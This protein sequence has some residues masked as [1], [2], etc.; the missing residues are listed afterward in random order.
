MT[1][2]LVKRASEDYAKLMV[3]YP[4]SQLGGDLS[5]VGGFERIF[6]SK[7]AA[8]KAKD[9]VNLSLKISGKHLPLS[10]PAL[11]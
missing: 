3:D 5:K 9:T 6:C 1:E 11:R 4:N 10:S 8:C 7:V 2:A